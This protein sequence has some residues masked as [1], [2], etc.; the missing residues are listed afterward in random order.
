MKII[1]SIL[2]LS[3]LMV[4]TLSF[5]QKVKGKIIDNQS[6]EPLSYA[7]ITIKDV[8]YKVLG[9]TITDEAGN[10]ELSFS[11][12]V[13]S[14]EV[15]HLGYM[16]KVLTAPFNFKKDLSISLE[17]DSDVLSEVVIEGEKT[18]REFLIDRK[19]INFGSDL[20]TAGGTVMEAFEQLPELEIDPT[21]QNISLRGS[22]NVRILVNGRPSPLNNA[23]LL[24][25]IDAG[26]VEKVEII[27]SPSARYQADGASGIVNIILKDQVIKGL[28]GSVNIEG[29]T[30]PAYGVSGNVTG[31]FGKI[32]IQARAGYRDT[33]SISK[34]SNDRVFNANT[35]AQGIAT[36]REFDGS[37]KNL[38]LKAD[39]FINEKN[40]LSIGFSSTDNEHSIMPVTTINDLNSGEV[41]VN[42]LESYHLHET[43]VYN[44]NYRKRFAEGEK[45][46]LDFDITL[47]DNDNLLPSE[48]IENGSTVLDNDLF[49][50]N[51][52]LNV[53]GDLFWTFKGNVKL[54][55]GFLYTAKNIDNL[56]ISANTEGTNVLSYIY[57]EN[58]YAAYAII[59]QKWDKVGLQ[60]GLRSEYF[61]SDGTIN[62]EVN[63]IER[64]FWNIFPSLHLSFQKSDKLN[65][66]FGYNRRIS[67]PSFYSLNPLTSINSPLFRRVGNPGLTPSFTDNIEFGLRYNTKAISFNNSLYYR[68]S[69]DIINRLFE[70]QDQVTI[71][72]F[73]N[74]G[75]DH[76]VGLEST[77]SKDLN[78]NISVSITGTGYYKR[79]DPQIMDFFYENQ[80]NYQLRTKFSIRPSKKLSA[81]IQWNYFGSG[82]RLNTTSEVFNF[83]NIAIRY[84]V[85]KNNGTLSVRFNDIF[86]GNIY[87]NQRRSDQIVENMRWL[88]QTRIAILSFNYRFSKG[89]LKKRKQANKNYNES[90]ALE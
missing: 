82:R 65:Y 5:A 51:S 42:E 57:D 1:K 22:S 20:Q 25:Q 32:N 72:Q 69:S 33:Y 29:R 83:M 86:R 80:Y 14:V 74:G 85:L 56:E 55:A 40:D 31:G 23:D 58:T 64:E 54:E 27:T 71:M 87:E 19:V 76:T 21:T 38:N 75:E 90:G 60:I 35:T 3:V 66:S 63:A 28:A 6:K 7:T 37:V 47:N 78:S 70:I 62:N 16:T 52:I 30:N 9:G 45:R 84:K 81:D 17:A 73:T 26:Q 10:F 39:W 77:V 34:T 49:Y 12:Q 88:G 89:S 53:A 13:H 36:R 8:E 2:T 4:T 68:R 48:A 43:K 15:A 11:Q 61:V 46:Y 79:A 59:N 41:T 24:D 44:L 50:D 18:S 67:R